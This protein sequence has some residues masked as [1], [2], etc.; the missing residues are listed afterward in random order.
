MS[1]TPSPAAVVWRE[2]H[3]GK[4]AAQP[5]RRAPCRWPSQP[6]RCSVAR[7]PSFQ[8]Q[9]AADHYPAM[10]FMLAPRRPGATGFGDPPARGILRRSGCPRRRRTVRCATASRPGR[11]RLPAAPHLQQG[12]QLLLHGGDLRRP[13]CCVMLYPPFVEKNRRIGS[14]V[15]VS[16]GR[17]VLQCQP[18]PIV[19]LFD[20]R[21]STWSV[22]EPLASRVTQV[23]RR[24]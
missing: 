4:T 22:L 6:H 17:G 21:V 19:A 9:A 5:R 23:L 11:D 8:H 2:W 10:I 20:D 18:G 7:R 14:S 15:R 13:L 16:L 1:S 3:P 24:W 12:C